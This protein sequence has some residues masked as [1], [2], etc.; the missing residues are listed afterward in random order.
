M[1]GNWILSALLIL[2]TAGALLLLLLRGDGRATNRNARWIA[3]WTTLITFALSLIAWA[4]FD[5]S[6]PG[7]QLVEQSELTFLC[8]LSDPA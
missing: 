4:K 1:A 8:A 6:Q 2:P 5:T 3:L 7:F